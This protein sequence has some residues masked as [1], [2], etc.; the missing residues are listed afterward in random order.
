MLPLDTM[1][2]RNT[3]TKLPIS[4]PVPYYIYIR[5]RRDFGVLLHFISMLLFAVFN[6]R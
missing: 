6:L 5:E 1:Q 2:S 4:L 3:A